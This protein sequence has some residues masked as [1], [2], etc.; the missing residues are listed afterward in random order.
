MVL[1]THVHPFAVT[2]LVVRG[3]MSLTAGNDTR[4]L[5]TGDTFELGRD[6][7][8]AERYDSAGTTYW[9]ARRHAIGA[10]TE[11]AI[12]DARRLM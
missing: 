3:E 5:L 10:D 1:D 12:W 2:A 11:C 4:H 9:V 7:S 8:H 6:V